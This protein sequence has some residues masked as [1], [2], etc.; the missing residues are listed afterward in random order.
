MAQFH[1][2]YSRTRLYHMQEPGTLV[3]SVGSVMGANDHY[4]AQLPQPLP[5]CLP[6]GTQL[7]SAAG[8]NACNS[9]GTCAIPDAIS[10]ELENHG[11]SNYIQTGV[12]MQP[13]SACTIDG[14]RSGKEGSTVLAQSNN[15]RDADLQYWLGNKTAEFGV[16]S[17][18]GNTTSNDS[19][20]T[21]L[22]SSTGSVESTASQLSHELGYSL[23][24]AAVMTAVILVLHGL[25]LL[26]WRLLAPARSS[27]PDFLVFPCFEVMILGLPLVALILYAGELLGQ[28]STAMLHSDVTVSGRYRYA[29]LVAL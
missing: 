9:C 22:N 5:V 12:L 6:Q 21:T 4:L 20:A 19:L 15:T 13:G 8:G 29:V 14:R 2:G 27:P 3:Q 26:L 10:S 7:N 16:F 11:S 25:A 24:V 1:S 18:V 28:Y 23:A 17:K